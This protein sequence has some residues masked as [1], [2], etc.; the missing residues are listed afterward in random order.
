M[1]FIVNNHKYTET[2]FIVKLK[3]QLF[4]R[5]SKTY[6]NIQTNYHIF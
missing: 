1:Y 3:K 5:G 6:T 2:Y 4:Q